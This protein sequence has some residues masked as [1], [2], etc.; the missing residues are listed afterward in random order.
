MKTQTSPEYEADFA[1]SFLLRA[2]EEPIDWAHQWQWTGWS[3][4]LWPANV[5][6]VGR[7][8]YAFDRRPAQ[9]RF[10][11]LLR[12]T[13]GGGFSYRTRAEY[14]EIVKGMCKWIPDLSDPH[15]KTMPFVRSG[16]PRTG[17]AVRWEFIKAVD[18]PYPIARFPRIGWLRLD[19]A[20]PLNEIC[21]D[22]S[23]LY[24][25]GG[26]VLRLHRTIE[27][28]TA[29]RQ[30]AQRYWQAQMRGRLHCSACGFDF[31]AAYGA[32]GDGFIEMHHLRPLG[33][34]VN[35]ALCSADELIPLC[36][37]CHRIVHRNHREFMT[38]DELQRTIRTQRR[39][40]NRRR[41]AC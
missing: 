41:V 17:L 24:P 38:L 10:C 20:P 23:D 6:W 14:A 4:R 15:A 36:S 12:I 8:V 34:I 33:T 13:H 35:P 2:D 22:A 18:I 28:S 37:N 26:R 30:R 32:A 29:L 39:L 31:A 11:A 21:L 16:R 1:I 7:K 25:E 40:L 5:E 3:R 9:R 19:S 27:R